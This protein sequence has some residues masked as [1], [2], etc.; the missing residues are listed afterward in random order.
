MQLC[1]CHPR[2][3]ELALIL[4]EVSLCYN[5]A[6]KTIYITVWCVLANS[7]MVVGVSEFSW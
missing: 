1:D 5:L 7:D 2:N 4:P 3:R 6:I